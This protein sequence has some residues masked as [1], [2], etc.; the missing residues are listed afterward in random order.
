MFILF[1]RLS[2]GG[3]VILGDWDAG[4]SGEFTK[5]KDSVKF[6]E[7]YWVLPILIVGLVEVLLLLVFWLLLFWFGFWPIIWFTTLLV[8]FLI[9]SELH[10]ILNIL[11][12]G[13]AFWFWLFTF[14]LFW[15][16]LFW[17][18]WDAFSCAAFTSDSLLKTRWITVS[19]FST[20]LSNVSSS[21]NCFPL[22]K[23]LCRFGSILYISCNFFLRSIILI[24]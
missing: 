19:S 7:W 4:W 1:P 22:F 13:L 18:F 20:N 23:S 17:L 3:L 15:V 8:K 16:L 21:L 14:T 2:G 12:K 10:I 24:S 11:W 9:S 6:K 5:F